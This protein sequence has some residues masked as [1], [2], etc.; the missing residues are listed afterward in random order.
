MT[1]TMIAVRSGPLLLVAL[2]SAVL[3]DRAQVLAAGSVQ[4]PAVIVGGC[5]QKP[6]ATVVPAT[7]VSSA[8]FWPHPADGGL[9]QRRV[10]AARRWRLPGGTAVAVIAAVRAAVSVAGGPT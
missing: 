8:S 1:L 4:R 2:G 6:L 5:G 9:D 3:Q 7:V 10:G